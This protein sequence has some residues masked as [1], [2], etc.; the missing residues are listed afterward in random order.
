M[1]KRVTRELWRERYPDEVTCV[2]CLEK[3]DQLEF[4]RL[5]WCESCR[6]TARKRAG[7]WGW[8]FGAVMAGALAAWIRFEVDPTRLVGGWIATVVAAFWLGSRIATEVAYGVDRY[9]NRRAVEAT[10]PK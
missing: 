9:R 7:R 10:P 8:V 3:K 2:R 1:S 6:A 4:D 5:L